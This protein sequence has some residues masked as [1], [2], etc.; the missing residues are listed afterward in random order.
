MGLSNSPNSV[1]LPALFLLLLCFCLE[2]CTCM[3]TITSTQ[4]IQDPETI[5][6]TDNAFKLGF[7]TPFNSTKRYVGIMYNF[8][9]TSE[10]QVV[11]VANRDKPLNDLF[12][13]LTIL[14]DGNL[15]VLDGKKEL[16]WSSNVSSP[17][18]NSSA[19]LLDTGDLVLEDETS[20]RILWESFEHPSNSYLEKMKLS[21][22]VNGDEKVMITSW[23]S[24]SDPSI[25]KYSLG[26]VPL[27]IPQ[28]FIWNGTHPYWRSGPW[29]LQVF[30]GIPKMISAV[31]LNGFSLVKDGEGSFSLSFVTATKSVHIYFVLNSNG[32]LTEKTLVDGKQDWEVTGLAPKDDCDI[33]GKCGQFGSCNIED[34]PIC[35]CLK[36]FEPKNKEEWSRGNWTGGCVRRTKLQCDRNNTKGEEGK[37]DGFSKLSP[38]KVP[39]FAEWKDAL[40]DNCGSQC[41]NNC[42]CIAYAYYQ[43]VGCMHWSGTLVDIQKFSDSGGADL[44]IRVAYTE[45]VMRKKKND[46]L[47]SF[48]DKKRNIKV[49]IASVIIIGSISVV[50]SVYFTWK[51]MAKITGNT[52]MRISQEDQEY[53]DRGRLQD[54]QEVAVKRLSRFSGQGLKEFMNEVVVISKLQHRNLVKLLGCCVQG[55]EKLLIYEYLPN[56][57]LDT[58]LFGLHKQHLDWSTC[59][60]I[61]EG[62]GR[63]LL[64]LHRDSRLRIIHRDLKPSNILLDEAL[65]PKISDFGMARIFG[66]NEDQ[67]NTGRIAGTFG[68]MAPEYA[69]EGRFSERSDVYSFGVLL[70]EIVSGRKNNS[71]DQDEHALSLL[72]FAWKLWN[73]EKIVNLI[74]PTI[75]F[76]RF[77]QMEVLRYIQVGL[78]CVQ[79]LARDR[80]TIS[81]VLSMLSSEIVDLPTPKQPVLAEKE[82]CPHT[83]LP[84]QSQQTCSI[85][86]YSLT[87]V[88]GR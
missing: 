51:W 34:S 14:E 48:A 69:M 62:I 22:H 56:K 30:I 25:G 54:G 77:S 43:G 45:L 4:F 47:I 80:P 50:V 29:N 19:R 61:I 21:T 70:L 16:L 39:D 3:N 64:Y 44:Y 63:G 24:P 20:G 58:H 15:A 67:A 38:V 88:E 49:V 60:N 40:Q 75:I 73:E 32:T 46:I 6:S 68:Y 72:G 42:S 18:T 10:P 27:H 81:T 13:T 35:T 83:V 57:S 79:D 11:W 31:L 7:F 33:Y 17:T 76:D 2:T 59:V 53:I 1:L 28:V 23:R 36:G 66:C 26:L 8:P 37:E 84:Q 9:V 74:D 87:T 85:K 55:E 86:D 52:P 12:G 78:L 5:I 82:T 71:F 65:N 41:L